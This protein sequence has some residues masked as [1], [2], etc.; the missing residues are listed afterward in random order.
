MKAHELRE[1]SIDWLTKRYP[2]SIIVPELSVAD[3]GGASL[4]VAAITATHIVGIEIK[5]EGDSPARLPLQDA[6][7]SRV[8]KEMW[9]LPDESIMD[10]CIAASAF[11]WGI[12]EI[13]DDKVRPYNKYTIPTGNLIPGKT[14]YLRRQMARSEA[15]YVPSQPVESKV[16]CSYS[17]CGTLWKEE[18]YEIAKAM[19]LEKINKSTRVHVLTE[20]VCNNLPAP[21]I[22]DLMIN[23]L[24]KRKWRKAV[25]DNRLKN[26]GV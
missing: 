2:E 22:H 21:L 11:N 9:V 19:G 13:H 20:A 24:L 5:G 26:V 18:L 7:Y 12:L 1:L 16:Q 25:I 4:D 8:V 6:L 23:Q 3:W 14:K 10:K 17:M 15:K